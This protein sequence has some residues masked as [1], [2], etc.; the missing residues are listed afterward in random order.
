DV[1]VNLV[2]AI[3]GTATFDVKASGGGMSYQWYKNGVPLSNGADPITGR[4]IAGATTAVLTLSNI[5]T[6]A[7]VGSYSVVATNTAGFVSSRSAALSVIPSN[8]IAIVQPLITSSLDA[9]T[10]IKGLA[11]AP[12]TITANTHTAST[13]VTYSVKSLPKGLKLNSKTGVIS[14]TPTKTGTHYVTLLASRKGAGTA[15]A[16]KPFVVVNPP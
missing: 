8:T 10:L 6:T 15:S 14:G 5:T 9:I 11:M 7:D 4:I 3:P 16:I 13:P 1:T 2:P 12:Y